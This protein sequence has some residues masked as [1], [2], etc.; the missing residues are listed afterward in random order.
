M[1]GIFAPLIKH[2]RA[3]VQHASTRRIVGVV[4]PVTASLFSYACSAPFARVW[5]LN[6]SEAAVYGAVYDSTTHRAIGG[7]R[8][9]VFRADGQ[10]IGRVTTSS[11]GRWEFVFP[12]SVNAAWIAIEHAEYV[13]ACVTNDTPASVSTTRTSHF[14]SLPRGASPTI[15][16]QCGRP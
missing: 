11:V 4:I 8:V 14:V 2:A 9:R 7:A 6:D 12:R 10:E 16:Q 1:T 15:P 5:R 3:Q 13:S